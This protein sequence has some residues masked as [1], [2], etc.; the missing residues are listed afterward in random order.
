MSGTFRI[1]LDESC[2]GKGHSVTVVAGCCLSEADYEL[3]NLRFE[4]WRDRERMQSEIKW[5]KVSNGK[6]PNYKSLAVGAFGWIGRKQL[7]FHAA[8]IRRSQLRTAVFHDGD[9]ELELNRFMYD[10]IF[11]CHLRQLPDG[12]RIKI[13]PDRRCERGEKICRLQECLNA[14]IRRDHGWQ[15]YRVVSVEPVDSKRENVSQINDVLMGAIGFHCNNRHAGSES[16]AAKIELAAHI[17]T[18][19]GLPDLRVNTPK[20]M[21]HFGIWQRDLSKSKKAKTP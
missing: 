2:I 3:L 16:S 6:L 10:L 5:T 4:N 14:G 9:F 20:H 12:A 21:T 8:A 13:H 7:A 15:R 17:A 19:A 18:L 11:H 1:Y